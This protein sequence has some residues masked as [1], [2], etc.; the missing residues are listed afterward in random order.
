MGM[1]ATL[2]RDHPPA[3]RVVGMSSDDDLKSLT[4]QQYNATRASEFVGLL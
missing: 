4:V 2:S 1:G 3:G